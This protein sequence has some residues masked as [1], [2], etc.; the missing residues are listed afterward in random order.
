MS[1]VACEIPQRTPGKWGALENSQPARA[2]NPAGHRAL[3]CS[4]WQPDLALGGLLGMGQGFASL[5]L[6]ALNHAKPALEMPLSSAR[7]EQSQAVHAIGARMEA[8][9]AISGGA[10][11]P[12]RVDC[13][14]VVAFGGRH[15]I[16][17]CDAA[18]DPHP[19][20]YCKPWPRSSDSQ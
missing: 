20:Q 3:I 13:R 10:F 6:R 17:R 9:G 11:I 12:P 2:E 1:M 15:G 18:C 8:L 19:I 16:S 14:S 5:V 7:S 4:V